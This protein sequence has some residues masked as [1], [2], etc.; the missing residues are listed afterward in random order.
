MIGKY[1]LSKEV[2]ATTTAHKEVVQY[3]STDWDFLLCRA[4]ANGLLVRV[5]NGKILIGPPDVGQAPALKLQFGSTILEMD[6]EIDAR[7]QNKGIK[8]TS[9][10]AADQELIEVE[11]Q[12][13][14]SLNAGNLSPSNLASVIGG[15]ATV[16]RHGG[17]LSEPE[18]QAWANGTLLKERLSKIRGR[19]KCQGTAALLPGKVVEIERVGD[20]ID[21]KVFVSGVRHTMSGGNWE[22]DA[23]FG[24]TTE[25]FAETY[26][27]R[28]LPAEGL[29]PAVSGLQ[30]GIV[31]ALEG[32]PDGEDR[33]QVRVPLIS[34]E[35]EGIWTR[36]ATLDAGQER[37]TFFRPEIGDEVIVGFLHDDPRYPVV[38]GML[39]SSKKPAPQP[40]KDDNHQKGYVSR[41]KMKLTFDDEKKIV[42]LETPSGN[43]FALTE[44]DKGIQLEDQNGNKVTL[45]DEG[46]TIESFKDVIIKA[47][48]DVKIEGV[49]VTAKGQASLT[50][51]ASGNTVIK[52]SI[53]QIN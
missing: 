43:R 32:D 29:L 15:E 21:G 22:T 4:E 17:K 25:R 10:N 18:L 9:W 1:G 2:S 16:L 30:V 40:P 27:L 38:L 35:E 53:V 13:P 41:E 24:L 31:T 5:E 6:A 50:A 20:R 45:N 49:N 42:Q 7:Y 14:R 48:R 47:V 11:A 12:E 46:I 33:I 19:A 23:Q 8:A 44:E 37:G 51:E 36:L 52:G 26:N 3:N 28:P 34:T 39:H